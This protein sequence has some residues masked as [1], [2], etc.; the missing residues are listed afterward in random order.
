MTSLIQHVVSNYNEVLKN[1]K[2]KLFLIKYLIGA[3]YSIYKQYFF[4]ERTNKILNDF[5]N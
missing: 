2:G 5:K 1:V 3:S 4:H